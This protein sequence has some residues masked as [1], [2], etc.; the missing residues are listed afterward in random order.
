M[1][2]EV[3]IKIT[4]EM[5]KAVDGLARELA[6]IRSGRAIP[7]LV[8]NVMIDYHGA[9]LPL[10]QIASVSAPEANLILIQPWERSSLRSI[11]K[12]ILKANIGFNPSNDGNV[13]RISV[14]PLNE[15]R[16]EELAKLVSKRVEERRVVLRNTRREGITKLRELEK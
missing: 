14:P 1:L 3:A 8:E 7:S 15:E 11:E 16:R 10:R 5:Q 9:P 4:A 2:H 6:T 13:V 12:G